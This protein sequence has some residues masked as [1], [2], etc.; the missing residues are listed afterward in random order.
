MPAEIS[1]S[2]RI[3]TAG[4]MLPEADCFMLPKQ[5]NGTDSV[6]GIL[7]YIFAI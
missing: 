3:S 1:L 2:S 4:Q 5:S 7:P 6:E